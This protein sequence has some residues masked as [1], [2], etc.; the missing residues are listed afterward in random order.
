MHH[1][2]VG[3]S[4]PINHG[5][6][7]RQGLIALRQVEHNAI[8]FTDRLPT[9]HLRLNQSPIDPSGVLGKQFH[10]SVNIPG[11]VCRHVRVKHSQH[12]AFLLGHRR[13][14]AFAAGRGT[15]PTSGVAQLHNG[16]AFDGHRG[17]FSAPSPHVSGLDPPV[18]GDRIAVNLD[19]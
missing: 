19:V 16:V 9:N 11:V 10:Y 18:P 13:G 1:D 14:Q 6:R 7:H 12:F 3:N 4:V 15:H 17:T 2:V 5:V 8:R